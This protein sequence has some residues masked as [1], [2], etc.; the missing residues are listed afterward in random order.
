MLIVGITG[1][2]ASGK[3]EV[4]KVFQKKG[5]IIISGDEIGKKVV[6]RNPMV[7]K[8]IVKAFG[9]GILNSN[10][11]LNRKK[12]GEVAFASERNKDKLN[13]IVHPYLLR[14]LKHEITKF[15]K[16]RN[17]KQILVVDA[18]LIVEWKLYKNLDKLI[19]VTSPKEKRLARLRKLGFSKKEASDRIKRQVTDS[20]RRRYSDFV[21]SNNGSLKQLKDKAQVVWKEV[22]SG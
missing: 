22:V 6:E 15:P 9:K 12:L 19:L 5:A 21:I 1:G 7:L 3:T 2:I 16:T 4:A 17:K 14:E 13:R 11:K 10:G 18:A 8:K 20:R